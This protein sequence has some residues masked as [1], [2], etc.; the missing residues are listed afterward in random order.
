MLI[1]PCSCPLSSGPYSSWIAPLSFA[2]ETV[3]RYGAPFQRT[4]AQKKDAPATSANTL[5]YWN[6]AWS[7]RLS[8]A[9]TN[10]ISLISFPPSTKMLHFEG[11]VHITVLS[12][13]PG[14]KDACSYPGRFA[15]CRVALWTQAK[16]STKWFYIQHITFLFTSSEQ[17]SLFTRHTLEREFQCMSRYYTLKRINFSI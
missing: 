4:S 6:S 9:V 2:Y 11:F 7:N 3:T 13:I 8:L 17:F 14:S 5:L 15:A 1:H 12:Q 10:R 16:P